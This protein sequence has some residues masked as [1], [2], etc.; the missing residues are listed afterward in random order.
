M[1]NTTPPSTLLRRYLESIPDF[2]KVKEKLHENVSFRLHIPGG[3]TRTGRDRIVAGLEKE[4][5]TIYS[6]DAFTLRV[7]DVFGNEKCAAARF[8]I[9]AQTSKGPYRNDY[10]CMAHFENDLL[11]EGWE[12]LDSAGAMQ[13]LMGGDK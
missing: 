2:D 1:N 10:C 7:I 8:E 6:R 3:K 13:Q 11:V 4:F 12:Y 9:E 5:R